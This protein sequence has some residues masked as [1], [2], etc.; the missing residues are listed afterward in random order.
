MTT[1]ILTA[2]IATLG[3]IAIGFWLVA[4]G[5]LGHPTITIVNDSPSALSDIVIRGEGWSRELSDISPGAS[6]AVVV[7]PNGESG[8]EIA[9]SADGKRFTKNDLAYIERNGGYCV[10]ITICDDME[11]TS[12]TKLT[13]F[14][15][16]RCLPFD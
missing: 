6:A 1:K 15:W 2:A 8:L 10:A 12:E 5:F 13:C 14:S 7:K 16:R 11:I 4:Q 3:I 9:F